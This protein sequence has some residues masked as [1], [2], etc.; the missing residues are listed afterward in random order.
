[1]DSFNLSAIAG[2]GLLQAATFGLKKRIE[3]TGRFQREKIAGAAD[4]DVADEDLRH[5]TAT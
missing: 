4:M 3:T 1:M 5:G 2:S